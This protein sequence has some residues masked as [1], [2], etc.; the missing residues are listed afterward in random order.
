VSST[1]EKTGGQGTRGTRERLLR[2]GAALAGVVAT[3]LRARPVAAGGTTGGGGARAGGLAVYI[4]TGGR[5]AGIH[6]LRLDRSTGLLTFVETTEA[7]TDGWITFDPAQ[8]ALYAAFRNN[9]VAGFRLDQSS[10]RLT[11]GDVQPT[12]TGGYPHISVDPTGGLLLG[13]SYGGGSVGVNPIL[14]EGRL[15]EPTQVIPHRGEPGPVLPDQSQP[16]PHQIP[17]DASGRWAIVPDLG[18]DR[19]YAYRPNTVIGALDANNPPYVQLDRGRGPRH[20]SFHPSGRWA[21]VI[22]E[23]DSTMSA[24]SWD[25]ARGV[26]REI[27]NI[28]T[29]REGWQGAR[30]SAQVVVHPSGRWVYGSNRDDNGTNPQP[31]RRIGTAFLESDDL[32]VFRIDQS[33]GMLTTVGHQYSGGKNPRNFNIDPSGQFLI[34]A[35]QDSD[36][37]TVF[38]INQATGMITP[39]GQDLRG[40]AEPLCV[41]FAPRVAG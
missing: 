13:A 40:M 23:L 17:F 22:N 4:G 5:G 21:Y 14:G 41:Q 24:F 25:S 29:L 26:L 39:T 38:R 19:V 31:R 27:Q 12:G 7:P 33:T 1:T 16:H 10:G 37:V 9:R 32:V 6:F 30:W 3:G 2:S 11:A 8:R 20:A 18:L 36:N 15:G 35:H 28:S 34:C